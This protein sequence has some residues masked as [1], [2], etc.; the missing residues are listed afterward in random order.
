[1]DKYKISFS[2]LNFNFN[3]KDLDFDTTKELSA[4]DEE[5]I[6][7]NRA[8]ASLD[9]GMRV[10]KNGYNIFMAGESGTGKST[11][12]ENMAEEKSAKMDPPKDILYVFNFSESEI[13]RVMRVPAGMGSDL[14]NDM[15]KIIEEL[16][17][18]I[19]R[20]FEGEEYDLSLI[21]I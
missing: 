1:M 2:E 4:I 18:E 6:G 20:A 13:P 15:D 8:A 17:E 12:A 11:Y 7:Q 5:I 16:Q 14:K 19:P 3:A 21:H 9:F 10:N